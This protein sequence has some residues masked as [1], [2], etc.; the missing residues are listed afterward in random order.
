M[1]YRRVETRIWNDERFMSL[2]DDGQ[3][4]F[5]MLLTHPHMTSVGAMRATLPGLAAEKGWPLERFRN[6]FE[7]VS[8]GGMA[9]F[10][11]KAGLVAL[12]NFL[13]HNPPSNPNM[14]KGWLFALDLLPECSLKQT[15]INRCLNSIETVEAWVSKGLAEPFRNRERER[16]REQ[17]QKKTPIPPALQATAKPTA[18]TEADGGKRRT[19]LELTDLPEKWRVH[20][21]EK[22]VDPDAEWAKF[23]DHHT[24]QGS[25]MADWAAA[26]RTWCGRA[27][28]FKQPRGAGAQRAL[29][30]GNDARTAG[31]KPP[32]DRA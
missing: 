7:R 17:E 8:K 9:E 6:G 22:G 20:A 29:E 4:V 31:W 3:L 13:K 24:A 18:S 1:T 32:E 12:P 2:P 30:A 11:E 26:W 15:V 14:V 19:K 28:E 5:L 25:T 10:D 21:V 27:L 16:E 23:R